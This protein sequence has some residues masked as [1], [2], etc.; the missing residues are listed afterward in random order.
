M[1]IPLRAGILEVAVVD[2]CHLGGNHLGHAIPGDQGAEGIVAARQVPLGG[3][4]EDRGD[5]AG[6]ARP[7]QQHVLRLAARRGHD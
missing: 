1:A 7:D 6:A 3:A 4:G 5:I 2:G